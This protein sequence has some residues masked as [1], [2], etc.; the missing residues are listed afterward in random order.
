MASS[1]QANSSSIRRSRLLWL[2][3]V[4]TSL[5]CLLLTA[6]GTYIFYVL[7][8]PRVFPGWIIW[9]PLLTE[10]TLKA[11]WSSTGGY[12]RE[13][14]ALA[15]LAVEQCID[16][17]KAKVIA[18]LASDPHPS[19]DPSGYIEWLQSVKK[20]MDIPGHTKPGVPGYWMPKGSPNAS[21]PDKRE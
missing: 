3:R 11:L 10:P 12:Y 20:F 8:G 7:A 6:S 18:A 16:N 9:K 5:A 4:V 14:P 15:A 13:R 21:P 1:S 19:P 17:P 2:K